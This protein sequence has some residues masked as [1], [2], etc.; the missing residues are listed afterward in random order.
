[1]DN[2]NILQNFLENIYATEVEAEKTAYVKRLKFKIAINLLGA[3]MLF[4]IMTII[5]Q[6]YPN[7][8]MNNI[9]LTY[10]NVRGRD[11]KAVVREYSSLKTFCEIYESKTKEK[12]NPKW[13]EF[14]M[15]ELNYK[16]FDKEEVLKIV[17]LMQK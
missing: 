4:I 3:V 9:T 8:S 5:V 17:N 7:S 13:I 10:N 2:E 16:L 1:M 6:N 12:L 11:L 15:D 14:Q